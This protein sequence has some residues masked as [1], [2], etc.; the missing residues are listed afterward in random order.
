MPRTHTATRRSRLA[1]GCADP[2]FAAGAARP[3][4]S[5]PQLVVWTRT[6]TN[7]A[8]ERHGRQFSLSRPGIAESRTHR[9]IVGAH[10]ASETRLGEGARKET[11][12]D[13][14]CHLHSTRL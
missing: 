2:S 11:G 7:T 8:Q 10:Q 4:K 5:L 3:R 9:Q 1:T 14:G 12:P 6:S 13:R